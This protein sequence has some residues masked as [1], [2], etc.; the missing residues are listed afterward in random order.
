MTTTPAT[1]RVA[2]IGAGP[3]GL[4]LSHLLADAGIDSIV[5]DQRSR[6]DI[7][8]TIRAGILEQS[9]VE[10]LASS[11][12]SDRILQVGQRHD[13]V[14]LRFD[15]EGHRIDFAGLTGR[16][17]WLYPQHEVL[18]D[19]IGAR[20]AA[21]QDL[22]FETTAVS[23]DD[24]DAAR[25]RVLVRDA[26]GAETWIEAEFL[27]GAD[28]SRSIVRPA[29]TGSSHGGHFRE[30]PFAWFGILCEAPPSSEELIYSASDRGFALISRR[31]DT[32]Q[33]M[34]LQCDPEMDPDAM[35]DREI[36]DE[37]QARTQGHP[38]AE[39]RIFQRDVLRFR[40]FVAERLVRGRI[41]IIGDAAHTVPPTG[42]K[43]ANLAVADVVLLEHALRALLLDGD[44]RPLDAFTEAALDRIWKAQHFSWWMTSMLHTAPEASS[45]DRQR[46][47]GELRAVVGSESARR[48]LAECYT[49]WPFTRLP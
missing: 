48:F 35:T 17:V 3:A 49:G 15:G 18:I 27:V 10:L 2:I 12:A 6:T 29:V 7:E 5:V 47:R 33:R 1:T 46:Q 45:F 22:R 21:G 40:S 32:V 44:G 36:W 31:S 23:I 42:A 14:E 4:L 41:A 38:L 8:H 34:Y 30:Y 37:L 25:P 9:T 16:G 39:G 11:G 43:G 26:E 28:G 20:L 24:S 19:L 13:G